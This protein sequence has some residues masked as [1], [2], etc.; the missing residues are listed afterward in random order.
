M[1][2]PPT[3]DPVTASA[4]QAAIESPTN[5]SSH[6]PRFGPQSKD[7]MGLFPWIMRRTSDIRYIAE[8]PVISCFSDPYTAAYHQY[9]RLS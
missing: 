5:M 6:T 7:I 4:I 9:C 8:D 2:S 3:E 1:N